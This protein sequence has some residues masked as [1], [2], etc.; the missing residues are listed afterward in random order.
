MD[1]LSR[2]V[3]SIL[4]LPL[5]G[6]YEAEVTMR[7][8]EVLLANLLKYHSADM[9]TRIQGNIFVKRDSD[10][11]L[12]ST[13]FIIG[14]APLL[15]EAFESLS[16]SLAIG[17]TAKKEINFLNGSTFKRTEKETASLLAVTL[18]EVFRSIGWKVSK[19]ACFGH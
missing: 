18:E 4:G 3:Q 19:T 12:G 11:G 6:R 17:D 14:Y 10:H 2:A 1:R 5:D 16:I 7:G 13:E 8:Y 9:W 15:S